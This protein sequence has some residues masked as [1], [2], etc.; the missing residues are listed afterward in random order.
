[1]AGLIVGRAFESGVGMCS[2]EAIGGGYMRLIPDRN[3]LN[4]IVKHRAAVGWR[5]V[6]SK[7]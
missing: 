3:P 2:V 7:T 1:M 6:R 5:R 4:R